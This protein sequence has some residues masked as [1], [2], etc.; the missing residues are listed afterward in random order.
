MTEWLVT[1]LVGI[2]V[3][4]GIAGVILPLLPGLWLIWGAGLVYGLIVG[5]GA[6]GWLA[7]AALTVLAVGGTAVVYY[8]PAKKTSEV[9]IPWWGQFLIAGFSI[10]GFFMVPHRAR[11]RHPVRRSGR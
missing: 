1:I 7:M 8:L 3:A 10:A 4:V 11:G 9:G 6:A 2:V 5:F